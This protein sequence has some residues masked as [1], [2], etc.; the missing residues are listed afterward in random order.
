MRKLICLL[1]QVL[2]LTMCFIYIVDKDKINLIFSMN[3]VSQASVQTYFIF[4]ALIILV[5]SMI[6]FMIPDKSQKTA[7]KKN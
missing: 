4:I 3:N 2:S 7:Y 5:L 1:L 6:V